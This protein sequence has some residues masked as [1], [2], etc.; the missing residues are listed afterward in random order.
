MEVALEMKL[1]AAKRKLQQGYKQAE[2][3]KKR[4]RM[5]DLKDLP[6]QGFGCSNNRNKTENCVPR[7]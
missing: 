5:M 4:I 2:S 3:A 6:Q 7:S 1:E